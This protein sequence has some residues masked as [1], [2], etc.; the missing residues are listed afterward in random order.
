MF[1]ILLCPFLAMALWS[2]IRAADAPL[3]NA[4]A[5]QALSL[6][7]RWN[8]IVDP[9]D[10]GF[11]NYR[12][13]RF[14]AMAKPTGGYFLDQKPAT[15]S[16]LIE[17]DFDRSPVL[18]VP[19][20]W[21]SQDDKLFYYEGT[22]W[23]R[24]L[25]DFTPQA[26]GARQ[27]LHF[28]AA[29]YEADV[30]LNGRKLGRH[31]GGFTPFQFEVTGQ[32]R[33]AGNSLV[34][35]V[36]NQRHPEAVPTVNTDWWNYGGLTRDVMLLETPATCIRD[37]ALQ[38]QP[39]PARRVRGYVQLDGAT[40][41]LP[42]KLE[43]SSL[44][45]AVEAA[46][47]AAGRA[48]FEFALAGAALW[49][50]E[51]PQ[52]YE[53]VLTAGA[54]RLAEQVGFRTIETRGADILLN[55]QPVFLRGICLHEENPLRG[56]R[57]TTAAEAREMLGWARELGCNYVRLAHYPHNEAVAR[58]ADEMGILLWAE[59]PVYWTIHW[60]DPATY[61]NAENQL[62]ELI[63]RDRN[64]ASIIIWSIANETP[65]SPART[66]F[67]KKLAAHARGLDPTR[68][69]SAAMEVHADPKDSNTKI[70]EDPLAEVTDIVSFNQYIGWY[71]GVPDDCAKV[72]WVV[73]YNKPVL[74]SEFGGDAL[75]GKHGDRL[76]RFTEE[77]Q[78]DLYRQTL[79]ML[80][81]IPQ[82]RGMTPWILCDF[83]SPRRVLPQIQDGWN[84]KGLI[85]QNGTR[86]QAFSVLQ[87]FYARKAAAAAAP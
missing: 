56:G 31:T 47:D 12:L 6:N 68:L 57:A 9:Y 82:L 76:T 35:R 87:E 13:E 32:L 37:Y 65:V 66:T 74:I 59:V 7:G 73:P 81:K 34:V 77:Y 24:R 16:E 50:P 55:G 2:P 51:H 30:Y 10:N 60:E 20:D 4:A 80:E 70:V 46:T 85:G 54:D 5:R 3:I 25:F 28:G 78:A 11:V 86:K 58:V 39:G 18:N 21:N 26:A 8:V 52:R 40:P 48:T 36:N 1:R 75:Q 72:R 42:V 61:A 79:P 69:I 53:V 15:P 83:R 84:R 23:Y 63:T 14:D 62:G 43:I 17:Y 45:L 71:V 38:L 44:H 33:A 41:A 19:G 22:V 64:R 67:L 49:S 27:F 29:N